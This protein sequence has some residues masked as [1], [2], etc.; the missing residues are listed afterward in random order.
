MQQRSDHPVSRFVVCASRS[1]AEAGN[2]CVGRAEIRRAALRTESPNTNSRRR[3]SDPIVEQKVQVSAVEPLE[4]EPHALPQPS[5]RTHFLRSTHL[6]ASSPAKAQVFVRH[7]PEPTLSTPG[8]Q[9]QSYWARSLRQHVRPNPSFKRSANGRP[10]APG[11][12]YAVH[13]HRPGTGVLPLSPT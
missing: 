3:A 11:R 7:M 5:V 1:P 9:S 10:P 12:W 13:F 4:L 6:P 8:R 2:Q